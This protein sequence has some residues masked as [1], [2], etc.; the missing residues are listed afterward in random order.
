M[1]RRCCQGKVRHIASTI[2]AVVRQKGQ[3]S[4]MRG[5]CLLGE[6]IPVA[7][8]W[9]ALLNRVSLLEAHTVRLLDLMYLPCAK[10]AEP[11]AATY[12]GQFTVHIIV[13]FVPSVEQM[14]FALSTYPT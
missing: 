12:S 3:Q 13:C 2:T 1:F 7:T 6:L 9:T 11:L 10:C 8:Q 4:C 14:G 5:K